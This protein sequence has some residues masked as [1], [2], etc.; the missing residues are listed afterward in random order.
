MIHLPAALMTL[1][2]AGSARRASAVASPTET[3]LP[4]EMTRSE[5]ARAGFPAPSI[6]VAPWMASDVASKRP[7]TTES[8][9]PVSML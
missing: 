6:N 9:E 4:A 3:I 8:E 1:V 7:F 2:P 5:L